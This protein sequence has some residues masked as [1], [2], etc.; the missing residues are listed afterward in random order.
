MNRFIYTSPILGDGETTIA[1]ENNVRLYDGDQKV[2]RYIFVYSIYNLFLQTSFE[3]GELIITSHRIFWGRPGVIARGQTCLSLNLSDIVFVEEES[4]S[5]FNF[6][7]S[8]K[9]LVYL[10]EKP[11]KT[12][13]GNTK[14]SVVTFI[15]RI[16]NYL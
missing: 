10:I 13:C 7:R 1:V 15:T 2:V 3:G 14:D 12:C 9:L 4:P 8:R 5:A 11:G 16:K 6:S